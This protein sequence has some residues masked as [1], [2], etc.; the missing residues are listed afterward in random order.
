[1]DDKVS[2]NLEFIN[3]S[4]VE[5]NAPPECGGAPCGVQNRIFASVVGRNKKTIQG[6]YLKR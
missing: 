5:S 1:M 6:I 2:N 4:H 3:A